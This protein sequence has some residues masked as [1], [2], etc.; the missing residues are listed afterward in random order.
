MK[1]ILIIIVGLIVSS[2]EDNNNKTVK[3]YYPSGNLQIVTSYNDKSIIDSQ[4]VYF[5]SNIKRIKT[6]NVFKKGSNIYRKEY[7]ENGEIISEGN[8]IE[9]TIRVGK[10][11]FYKKQRPTDI[12]EYF[13]INGGNYVNQRWKLDAKGDTVG[14]PF[15]VYK[16]KE[17]FKKNEKFRVAFELEAPLLSANS[18]LFVCYT[19]DKKL[20][21]DF[22]NENEIKFDTVENLAVR[23][24]KRNQ[25]QDKNRVVIF[26]LV[27]PNYSC[28]NNL[29]GFLLEKIS[30][31]KLNTK[32]FEINPNDYDYVTHKIYFNFPYQVD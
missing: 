2:C 4:K 31:S 16:F 12:V 22:S 20:K 19:N 6:F 7:N 5:D 30:K 25:H 10:W 26:D 1:Y 17:K 3:Q 21:D 15:F 27:M 28:S 18:D 11:R 23:F 14:G 9:D 32:S 13:R 24:S 29:K 8:I